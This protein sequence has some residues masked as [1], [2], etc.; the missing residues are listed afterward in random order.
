MG[1]GVMIVIGSV[2]VWVW[3]WYRGSTSRS[4]LRRLR[5]QINHY[6]KICRCIKVLYVIFF[7]FSKDQK[8]HMLVDIKETGYVDTADSL[9]NNTIASSIWQPPLRSC[10]QSARTESA[11]FGL[12]TR[13]VKSD[14]CCTVHSSIADVLEQSRPCTHTNVTTSNFNS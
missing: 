6:C 14:S 2:G 8:W 12:F 9:K 7:Y 4:P 11:S 3:L 10:W 5:L 13:S 1:S